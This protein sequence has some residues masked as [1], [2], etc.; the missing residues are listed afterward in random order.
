MTILTR[1]RYLLEH[2]HSFENCSEILI[3]TQKLSGEPDGWFFRKLHSAI[4][5]LIDSPDF[6]WCQRSNP[7]AGP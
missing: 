7:V 2:I 5:A 6:L 4:L 3:E 1:L